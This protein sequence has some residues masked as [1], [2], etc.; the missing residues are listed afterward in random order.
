MAS[1]GSDV[2]SIAAGGDTVS[3]RDEAML[4]PGGAGHLILA[5][6]A[7]R[8]PASRRRRAATRRCTAAASGW[9]SMVGRWAPRPAWYSRMARSAPPT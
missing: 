9:R 6:V 8:R 2:A 1:D 4:V 5:G 7:A 3:L